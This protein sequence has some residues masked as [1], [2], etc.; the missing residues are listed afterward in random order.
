M[1]GLVCRNI[2]RIGP[3]LLAGKAKEVEKVKTKHCVFSTSFS[4]YQ[5][6]FFRTAII[7]IVKK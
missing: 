4:N 5:A 2:R 7:I 1:V 3:L 6:V